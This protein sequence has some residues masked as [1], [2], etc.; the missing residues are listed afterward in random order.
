MNKRPKII[1]T[2][3]TVVFLFLI[4]LLSF[5]GELIALN[6]VS[7]RQGYI[8]LGILLV[9]ELIILPVGGIFAGWLAKLFMKKFKWNNAF[10]IVSAVIVGTSLGAILSFLSVIISILAAGIK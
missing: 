5:F 3:L 6:D 10:A 7:E 1:A 4:A 2:I 8:A 9:G